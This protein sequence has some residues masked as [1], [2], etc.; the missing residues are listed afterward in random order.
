MTNSISINEFNDLDTDEK[1]WHLWHG[2]SFLHVYE[3]PGL[4]I[5]LFYLNNYYIELRYDI[6]GSKVDNI[7]A[8]QTT[9]KLDPFLENIT[10]AG[11]LQN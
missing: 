5:N 4:R 2:A 6:N 9:A 1:A 8:F 7:N 3:K 10:I 11:L